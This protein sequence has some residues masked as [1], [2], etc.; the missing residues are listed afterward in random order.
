M[1]KRNGS[2]IMALLRIVMGKQGKQ[3]ILSSKLGIFIYSYFSLDVLSRSIRDEP[4]TMEQSKLSCHDPS[5]MPSW[6]KG[7]DE[8]NRG[9]C[10]FL[11]ANFLCK[12]LLVP[13]MVLQPHT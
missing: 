6:F 11:P 7:T 4:E 1:G 13:W 9:S 8:E 12:T 2:Q 5:C 3:R 10:H